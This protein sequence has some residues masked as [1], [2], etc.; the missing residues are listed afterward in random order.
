[1]A[2]VGAGPA[3][4]AAAAA[5]ARLGQSV[6]LVDP[7]LE[8][9]VDTGAEL[10]LDAPGIDDGEGGHR[11]KVGEGAAPGTPQL[12]GEIFGPQTGGFTPS[13]HVMCPGTVSAWGAAE[14]VTVEHQF[15]PLGPAWN[16]D[17]GGFDQDLRTA[18][19]RL[20]VRT[21]YGHRDGSGARGGD[22]GADGSG[23]RRHDG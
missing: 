13:R 21:L 14:P 6:T 11:A 3:G 7:A 17:R 8:G 2:V 1:M 20:G 10:G 5:V 16:L 19:K 23:R 12:V 4:C 15:N 9:A 22:L 18:A